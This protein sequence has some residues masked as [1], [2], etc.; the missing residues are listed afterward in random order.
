MLTPA[1]KVELFRIVTGADYKDMVASGAYY[2][3][4]SASAATAP[5]IF[6]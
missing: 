5:G 4:G 1:Q 3:F 6:S 2:F